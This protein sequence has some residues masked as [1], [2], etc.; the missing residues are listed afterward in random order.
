MR[1]LIGMRLIIAVVGLAL[2]AVPLLVIRGMVNDTV[3]KVT[4]D[5]G[6]ENVPS[7]PTDISDGESLYRQEN[8]AKALDELRSRAGDAELLKVGVLPYMAEFQIKAGERA[9]GYRYYAKNGEMGEFK[10]KIIG[11]GSLE[12][13][14]FPMDTVNAG[15]TAKLDG[16]V[17]E[18]DGALTV[19]N[20]T[21]ER[22]LTNGKLAWSINA[23]S[24]DRTGIVFLAKADGSGLA[25][26]TDFAR[27]SA[28]APTERPASSGTAPNVDDAL[29][30]VD[31]VQKADGDVTK[32]Q[33]CTN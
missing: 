14:Q 23:E 2:V 30:T 22:G 28:D 7:S 20:M 32:I 1:T 9:K 13:E 12:G 31:C 17:T 25:D 10:V 26:P 4:K 29:S 8:F 19:T 33:A 11:T 16:A 6:F 21:L 24:D 5:V 3:D 18:R 27:D 15:S